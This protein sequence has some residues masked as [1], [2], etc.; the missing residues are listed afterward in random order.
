[1]FESITD[2]PLKKLPHVVSEFGLKS[3]AADQLVSWLYKKRV[4]SFE[5]MTNL[6]SGV[7]KLLADRFAMS[8]LSLDKI[9]KAKDG[10]KKY[11]CKTRD[12]HG[13]ECVYIP[14]E[15]D[16]VTVCLSTQVGCAMGC[17][18]C[19]TGKMGFKRDL[20]QGEILGQ[21]ILIM[22]DV[23]KTITNIVLMGMGEPLANLEEVSNAVEILLHHNAFG[24]SKRRVTLSTSG[25]IP[26]LKEFCKHFD[27]KIAISLNAA[28]DVTRNKLMPINKR[29]K[30]SDIMAFC[31][32][33]S[34]T[35]RYKITFEYVLVKG[36][37]DTMDE[38]KKLVEIL[39]GIK[40]KINLIPYN[41]FDGSPFNAPSKETIEM[42]DKLLYSSGIQT[43]IRMSRGQEILAACGQLATGTP[44]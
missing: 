42:W 14:V 41:P 1:M 38:A 29:Y 24:F 39:K 2:I 19:R 12:G 7:R 32:E 40:A 34:K 16:R 10:T 13:I 36:V 22:K 44:S 11:L 5:E 31:R 35:A 27:V 3:Y 15:D 43:N 21:L 28:T 26:Q 17:E 23:P 20:T 8:A 33:Y 25:L 4:N 30:I 37:N 18:F 6:S 9:Q